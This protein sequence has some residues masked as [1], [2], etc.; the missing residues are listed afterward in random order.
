MSALSAR[1]FH[2]EE[3]AFEH[4]EGVVWANGVTCPHCG[5][6]SG[7]HYDLRKTRLGLRK[8]SD[9]RKQFTVK[10]GTVFESAHIPLHKMLQAVY[11]ICASKK[12]VSAHQLHRVLGITYKSAWFLAHRIR[13]AMR[14]GDLSPMGGNGGAVE[15]DET[16]I[17]NDRTIKPKGV[18][19]GRGYAHKHKVLSLVD[20]ESGKVRSMVVE[21]LSAKTLTPILRENI[22]KEA[23]VMTDEA[24][25]YQKLGNEFV[26]HG[27]TRHGQ[28]EYVSAADHTIHTNTIEGYF[29]IFKRGM[30]GVYQHCGK[31]HLH[32]YL[33]EFDFR[34][35]NRS[36]LGVEDSQRH[37]NAL[38]GIAGKRLTYRRLDAATS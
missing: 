18:K 1:Y 19:K 7:K 29:S 38:A 23:R 33:A 24:G 12:G 2:C 36:A 5:S 32:R 30:K 20:R 3:A 16:F 34:Y 11:L 21:S 31:Q 26:A 8:C 6:M 15:V 9:C 25:Q 14:S 10:V 35:N 4:L 13:E 27:F 37:Y 17:G 28:G 22:A